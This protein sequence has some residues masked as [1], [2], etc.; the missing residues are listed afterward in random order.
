V[1]DLP[2]E[3]S[4]W[5]DPA[6]RDS[7][8][9]WVRGRL[10]AAGMRPASDLEPR[11]R[12]WSVTGRI[13]TDQGPV[14][15][16]ANPPGSRFEPAL[17]AAL[18]RWVPG[19]VLTP[20]A[21]DPERGWSLLPDGGVILGTLPGLDAR[22]WEEPLRQYASLQR[23]VSGRVAEMAALGVPDLRPVQL[24]GHFDALLDS[25]DVRAQVGAAEGMTTAQFAAL[26]ALRPALAQWCARLAASPVPP[27]LDHS[28]LHD[29]QVFVTEGRY[30]FF[31]WG[32]AS[33]GHPFTSLLVIL[34]A[35]AARHG[36]AAGS[37]ALDRLR[38][39][40][41]EPWTAGHPAPE[42]WRDARLAIRL[43]AISR[44]LSWQRAFPQAAPQVRHDQGRSVAYWLTR[45]LEPDPG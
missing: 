6:W 16:K 15:F 37:A 26:Q 39:A 21:I 31:D 25:A 45:L 22:S 30:A 38:D 43:G 17:M 42:L 9:T 18:S 3:L 33:I 19:Q 41:L 32:D 7:A 4:P 27:S 34:R 40:Y 29:Y 23:A 5:G 24:P 1:N 11:L 36:L 28:D 35:A 12:P 20:V 8:L 13:R 10:R 44:A 14:W 2:A